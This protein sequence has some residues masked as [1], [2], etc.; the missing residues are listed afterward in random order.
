MSR[1]SKE[2]KESTEIAEVL[3]WP[4]YHWNSSSKKLENLESAQ[5]NSKVK[6]GIGYI[7][8]D[9]DVPT[10]SGTITMVF[11][12]PTIPKI[13]PVK[14]QMV[15]KNKIPDLGPKYKLLVRSDSIRLPQIGQKLLKNQQKKPVLI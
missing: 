6:K 4:I 3:Q 8:N 5:R 12:K 1:L 2:L 14:S 13:P 10:I 9:L 11:V 7:D 15:I